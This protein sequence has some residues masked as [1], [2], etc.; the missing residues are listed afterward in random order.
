[1]GATDGGIRARLSRMRT[2]VV[3]GV[4]ALVG[5]AG[6]PP[7]PVAEAVAEPTAHEQ[8]Q[9]LW[10]VLE[11]KNLDTGEVQPM[12]REFHM[13]TAS[14]EM[15]ILTGEDR[16]KLDK[17]LSDMTA[18]EVMSQ[19]P[20]GAGFYRYEVRGDKLERTNVAALS[21]YYEGKTF[22]TEFEVT[23]ETLVTRDRHSADGQLRQWT[24][25]RVE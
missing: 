4:F 5:C 8:L 20:I 17:S 25:E 19:Q 24:M 3:L 1:L 16:P 13:Y 9:G 22:E 12:H 18:D 21:A 23:A 14:H 15:I 2:L 10:R 7:T 6:T 11:I